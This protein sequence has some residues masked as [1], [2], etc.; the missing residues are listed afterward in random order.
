MGGAG[1]NRANPMYS[2]TYRVESIYFFGEIVRNQDAEHYKNSR[3][4]GFERI[5]GC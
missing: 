1:A 3:E 5:T 2:S 4:K